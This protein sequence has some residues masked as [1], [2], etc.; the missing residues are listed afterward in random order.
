MLIFEFM[1]LFLFLRL[2]LFCALNPYIV[3][4]GGFV[5]IAALSGGLFKFKVTTDPVQL[6]SSKT[7]IARQ[8]KE[9]FDKHFE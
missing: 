9:Y 6:W 7:S 4:I 2:G 8:Q 5:I 3:L 1:I